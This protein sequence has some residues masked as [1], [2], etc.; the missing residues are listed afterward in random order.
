MTEVQGWLIA[1][2]VHVYTKTSGFQYQSSALQVWIADRWSGALY[3]ADVGLQGWPPCHLSCTASHASFLQP[4]GCDREAP[5]LQ[6]LPFLMC[7]VT[8]K[9]RITPEVHLQCTGAA[10]CQGCGSLDKQNCCEL[11]MDTTP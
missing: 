2:A 9:E 6:P 8:S 10:A 4:Y 11:R 5:K 7:T 1:A 3:I